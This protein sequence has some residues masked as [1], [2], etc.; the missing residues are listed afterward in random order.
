MHLSRHQ[1]LSFPP[2][3]LSGQVMAALAE[4]TCAIASVV[5]P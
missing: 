2:F 4:A 5:D 1:L 3:A